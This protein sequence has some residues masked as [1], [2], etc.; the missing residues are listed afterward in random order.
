MLTHGGSTNRD[1]QGAD[2]PEKI[3]FLQPLHCIAAYLITFSCYGWHLPGQEGAVDRDHNV[4]GSRLREPR[5]KLHQYVAAS[6]KQ[7]PF[8]L[9]ADQ[10]AVTL[11]AIRE[12]CRYKKWLLLAAHVR[13]NHVHTVVEAAVAPEF[14]MNTFK[15]YA[16]RA[17]NRHGFQDRLRWARHGSTRYLVS[18]EEIEPAVRYVLDKQGEPMAF[19]QAR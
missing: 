5:A 6:L 13:T 2:R 11:E 7:E 10:R 1:R 4:P 8:E 3:P 12:V 18:R 14:V 9:D 15:S 19:H 16:S 17:L